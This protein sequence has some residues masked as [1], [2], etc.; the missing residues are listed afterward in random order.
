MSL[1]KKFKMFRRKLRQNLPNRRGISSRLDVQSKTAELDLAITTLP[2]DDWPGTKRGSRITFVPRPLLKPDS[3]VFAMG[4]CFAV[5]IR[6]ALMARGF[7]TLPKYDKIVFDPVVQRLA[8]LPIRDNVNH[9]NTFVIRQEFE[10]ALAGIDYQPDEFIELEHS[11]QRG[12]EGT[13]LQWQDP[14]RKHIFARDSQ[15]ILDISR[16][17]SNCIKD[18]IT[19]AD[20]YILTLGLTEV[21]RNKANGRVI[22]QAP[23]ENRNKF[24]F[25]ESTYEQNFENLMSVCSLVNS[26]FPQKHI[27]LTVSPVPLTRTF[28]TND[29]VVANTTSKSILRAVAA[30]IS[31]DTNNTTYWP[32]YE[33][34]LARDIFLE[35]GRHV[36]PD[37]INLIVDQFLKVHGAHPTEA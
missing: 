18:A 28:T 34:A 14:Y 25:E 29:V 35:D 36:R 31:K 27:I 22:N 17:V 30:Q 11:K 8:N 12:S 16:K 24:D 15:A 20:I 4:S 1:R 5:E 10:M 26:A 37:G 7:N 6:K 9:Y 2:C 13:V 33:I 32:S 21:W 23:A 19:Q 3:R